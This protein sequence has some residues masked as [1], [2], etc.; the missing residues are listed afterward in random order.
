[1]N[2]ITN[3][4]NKHPRKIFILL[5]IVFRL[6]LDAS[7]VK[8]IAP[9][10]YYAGLDYNPASFEILFTS[11]LL[12]VIMSCLCPFNTTLPSN[13]IIGL[14]YLISYIP[15]TSYLAWGGGVLFPVMLMTGGFLL[16]FALSNMKLNLYPVFRHAQN[17][18]SLYVVL[19]GFYLLAMIL[20]LVNF[21]FKLPSS[22]KDVYVVRDDYKDYFQGGNHLIAYFLAWL[23]NIAVPLLVT[24]AIVKRK[25]FMLALALFAVIELFAVAA[26]K[27]QLFA[28]IYL[29]V[30]LVGIKLCRSHLL[31]YFSLMFV[32]LIWV[33]SL[34][35]TN[36]EIPVMSDYFIRRVF[37]VPAQLFFY[38]CDYFSV[39]KYSY[40]SHSVFKYFI[41]YPYD[42]PIPNI[43]GDNY[44]P[45]EGVYANANLWADAFANFGPVGILLF[46]TLLFLLVKY[47]DN[48]A[49]GKNQYLTLSVLIMPV[50]SLS[51]SAMLTVMLTHGLLFAIFLVHFIPQHRN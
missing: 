4:L 6:S 34:I 39:N 36:I 49:F 33:S 17:Y 30:L 13:F 23:G 41:K 18:H 15:L 19:F 21:G 25:Y 32:L 31:Q 38:Y 16:V 28:I 22:M 43:I 2:K 50:Y 48:I 46:A 51:N 9:F 3:I 29:L 8:W 27:S 44:L 47:I 20:I 42:M 26:L 14:L 45:Y 10:H 24:I 37:V 1:M 11:Y 7:Y 12:V 5:V 35:D 40:L